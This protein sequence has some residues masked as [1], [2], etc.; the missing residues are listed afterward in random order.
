MTLLTLTIILAV[1]LVVLCLC[2]G[3]LFVWAL[4]RAAGQPVPTPFDECAEEH[5]AHD[6]HGGTPEDW[7]AWVRVREFPTPNGN[8]GQP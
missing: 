4:C 3:G 6:H 7:P 1:L 2:G 5:H 8:E